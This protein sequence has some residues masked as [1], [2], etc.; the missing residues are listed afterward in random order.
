YLNLAAATGRRTAYG[1][2]L[3][4]LGRVA[5][6]VE[7][8]TTLIATPAEALALAQALYAQGSVAQALEVA[9][10]GLALETPP[11]RYAG[12][13]PESEDEDWDEDDYV[14]ERLDE[15]SAAD[16]GPLGDY[17]R[18]TLARW[19]RDVAHARGRADLALR[20]GVQ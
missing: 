13:P 6:A 15:V 10:R 4:R 20:A 2:M 12:S 17:Q 18:A 11:Y 8:G 7:Y 5:D 9:E 3:L 1:Q 14:D 19:L 16:G